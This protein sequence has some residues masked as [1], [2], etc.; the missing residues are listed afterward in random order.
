MKIPQRNLGD[1][2]LNIFVYNE[3]FYL[4]KKE[5]TLFNISKIQKFLQINKDEIKNKKALELL[6][7]ENNILIGILATLETIEFYK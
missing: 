2:L 6:K 7:K 4:E 5:K 3:D 1:F